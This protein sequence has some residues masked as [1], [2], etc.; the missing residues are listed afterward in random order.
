MRRRLETAL[1]VVLVAVLGYLPVLRTWWFHDDWVFL[2]DAAGIAPRGDSLV[3]VLSYQWYWSAFYPL[4]G[5]H[6]WAWGLTRLALHAGSSL[7]VMRLGARA[8]LDRSARILAGMLFAA[9]PVAI[10][11]LYWGTG[12]IELMGVFFALAALERW[13]AG[14]NAARWWA[15]GLAA[16]A[17]LSKESGLLLVVVFAVILVRE[18]RLRGALAAGLAALAALAVCSALLVAR[19]FGTTGQYAVDLAH[20][21]RDLLVYG[22][23]LVL[24]APL[25]RDG[26]LSAN[27]ALL[28]GAAVWGAWGLVAWRAWTRGQRFPAA[29]LGVALL[30]VAPATVLGDHAVPR[31]LYGPFAGVALT[32]VWLAFPR[33]GLR[34]GGLVMFAIVLTVMAWSGT[35]YVRDARLPGGRPVHRL[36]FKEAI[37]RYS[38]AQFDAA[39]IRP[40]D[41]VVIEQGPGTDATQFEL[42][43]TT[44]MDDRAIRLLYGRGVTVRWGG[45]TTPADAGALSFSTAGANLVFKGRLP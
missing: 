1:P 23:W 27:L 9:A 45:V 8:G 2:A 31:Y 25:L 17:V 7:L 3:R 14:T 21:P 19:D 43:R 32:A 33:E 13:L 24:P 36:A 18:R 6:A 29:C 26:Q 39:H 11:S 16:L 41:H 34:R 22:L 37:S 12:A 4:F 10:E 5:L 28:A 38:Q 44:L 15:L 42:L 20:V 40:N 35:V 30:A